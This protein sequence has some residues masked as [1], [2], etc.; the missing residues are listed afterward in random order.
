ML[1]MVKK[2]LY[3]G[4]NG[5][6]KEGKKKT[7]FHDCVKHKISTLMH[8]LI[9]KKMRQTTHST[10][11]YLDKPCTLIYLGKPCTLCTMLVKGRCRR[12]QLKHNMKKNNN[13][14]IITNSC[15]KCT[16]TSFQVK[17]WQPRNYLSSPERRIK[18][19]LHT[20]WTAEN[21]QSP[22]Q[23]N[24]CTSQNTIN[25]QNALLCTC[26]QPCD[27]CSNLYKLC[28]DRKN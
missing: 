19:V 11:V 23:N 20:G 4:K 24:N 18:K 22:Q 17:F 26:L 1:Q 5:C 2:E 13:K 27:Y 3:K 12:L 6:F 21:V 9:S 28:N 16:T 8:F 10:L 15:S 14:E 7:N 25:N